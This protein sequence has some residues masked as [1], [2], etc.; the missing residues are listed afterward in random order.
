MVVDWP[1]ATKFWTHQSTLIIVYTFVSKRNFCLR[2]YKIITELYKIIAAYKDN[3]QVIVVNSYAYL[4]IST[5]RPLAASDGVS[6]V[7]AKC[8][9][10]RQVSG[11]QSTGWMS[12]TLPTRIL[13]LFLNWSLEVAWICLW[14]TYW[15][16]RKT[17]W[18]KYVLASCGINIEVRELIKTI[19][20][21][22]VCRLP[23]ADVLLRGFYRRQIFSV[24]TIFDA[25]RK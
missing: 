2:C 25:Q 7:F 9:N 22:P 13:Q 14:F 10:K 21:L 23:V 16:L 4:L 8:T 15:F 17:G 5:C 18:E 11:R 6:V 19:T 1:L 20:V 3:K 12:W 24:D